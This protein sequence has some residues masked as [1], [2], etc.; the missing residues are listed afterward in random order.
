MAHG[1][2]GGGRV[3]MGRHRVF[4]EA[5]E[6]P[7]GSKNDKKSQHPSQFDQPPTIGAPMK[8]RATSSSLGVISLK[9]SVLQQFIKFLD[10]SKTV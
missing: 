8:L 6:N 1:A 10:I 7:G 2:E 5:V 4:P 9:L 3:W